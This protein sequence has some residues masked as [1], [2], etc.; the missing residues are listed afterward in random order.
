MLKLVENL[1]IMEKLLLLSLIQ[2]QSMVKKVI[3]K[4]KESLI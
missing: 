1:N 3:K 2:L 4:L